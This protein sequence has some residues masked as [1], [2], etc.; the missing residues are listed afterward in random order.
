MAK[1]KIKR[2]L[3]S[4][5]IAVGSSLL[6]FSMGFI[7]H[8]FN[9]PNQ[10]Y[11]IYLDGEKLGVI[12]DKNELY[13]LIN[14]DQS[15]IKEKYQV[16]NVYPPKGFNIMARTTY[17]EDITS[18]EKIYNK[19][20][21]EKE[22]T[23]KGYTITIKKAD[24]DAIPVYINVLDKSVFEKAINNI[25][26]AFVEE[27]KYQAFIKGTQ[28]EITD[29]G[30]IINNMY[31]KENITIKETYISVNDP[32]FTNESDLT[33]YLL[34]GEVEKTKEYVIK[35]VDSI[36]TVAYNNKLNAQEFLIANPQYRSTNTLLAIGDTANVTLINPILTLIYEMEV[37]EDISV[38]Y[39]SEVSYDYSKQP[40]YKQIDQ[41]GVNGITRI[42]KQIQLIN[43]E[44]NQG[45]VITNS[46]VIRPVQNEKI[47]KG[48]KNY[49]SGTYVDTGQIWGWPTNSPYVITSGYGYRGG[50]F[51]YGLDISGTGFGSPIYATLDGVVISSGWGGMM[52]NAGGISIV[53]QHENGYCSAYAHLSKT[54]VSV[55]QTV[56]RGQRIGN[57]GS[58]GYSSGTHLHFSVS[59]GIPYSPSYSWINPRSIFH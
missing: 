41:Q 31:F 56:T 9:S 58:T 1:S 20:K 43:G 10:V 40:S 19:I 45:A 14:R 17:E 32:I 26:T 51:H 46:T 11:Q 59:I 16:K 38:P 15:A 7:K 12:D 33:K 55:G 23:I 8:E 34:F 50:E 21:A 2:A 39:D 3:I 54:L 57:M 29:V 42:T 25:I 27:E 30:S 22:F 47:V 53:V 52:G 6:I 13:N 37:V 18:V 44:E 4:L 36:E 35:A 49:Q 48:R 24:Q 5:F 28:L